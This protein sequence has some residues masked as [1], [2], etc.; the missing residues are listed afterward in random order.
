MFEFLYKSL[1]VEIQ[2]LKLKIKS[3]FGGDSY[4]GEKVNS[5]KGKG[6]REVAD[7]NTFKLMS[8]GIDFFSLEGGDD[9]IKTL[10]FKVENFVHKLN[11]LQYSARVSGVDFGLSIPNLKGENLIKSVIEVTP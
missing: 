5:F 11:D 9:V 7:K 6:L 4:Q 1:L 10:D 3:I 2:T 8:E